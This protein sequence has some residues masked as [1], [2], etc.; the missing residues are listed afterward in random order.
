MADPFAVDVLPNILVRY[1]PQ[2]AVYSAVDTILP[3]DITGDARKDFIAHLRPDALND[4]PRLMQALVAELK[5]RGM[6]MPFARTLL[7][8]L[9]TDE[10]LKGIFSHNIEV[11]AD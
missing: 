11:G 8:L 10:R 7:R 1:V 6:V 3:Q 5:T 2:A 4:P 9:P